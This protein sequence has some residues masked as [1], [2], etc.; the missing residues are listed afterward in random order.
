MTTKRSALTQLSIRILI[1]LFV[2]MLFSNVGLKNFFINYHLLY[3]FFLGLGFSGLL[4]QVI[5]KNKNAIIFIICDAIVILMGIKILL[6]DHS[7]NGWLLLLDFILANVLILTSIVNEPHC[8]WII[9]GIINGSGIVFLFNIT[10]HHY[11]SLMSLMSITLLIF[12]NI[13]F[14]FPVFMKKGN[15][16]SLLIILVLI[17][18][19]CITLEL[20]FLKIIFISLILGFYLFFEW[21]VNNNK[22]DKRNNTSLICLL[23]FSLAACL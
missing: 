23:L 4:S 22:Y 8:Q 19:I 20:T 16:L 21:K 1:P 10:Y 17:L 5:S 12:A 9:Y 15:R 13:F 6:S 14:S 2:W 18:A 11:F 7:F 3:L